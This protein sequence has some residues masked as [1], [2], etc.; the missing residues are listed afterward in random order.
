MFEVFA[1]ARQ[2]EHSTELSDEI[3]VCF[4]ACEYVRSIEK[5]KKKYLAPTNFYMK[6]DAV[7]TLRKRSLEK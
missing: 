2:G 1:R 7:Y 5:K 4:C 6:L 3:Y